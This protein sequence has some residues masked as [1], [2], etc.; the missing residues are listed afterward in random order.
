MPG[1]PASAEGEK[2][3]K[4]CQHAHKS[5]SDRNLAHQGMGS[6]NNTVTANTGVE[7]F[8]ASLRDGK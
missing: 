8:P 3:I 5:A 1:V 7:T 4:M 2:L 6:E